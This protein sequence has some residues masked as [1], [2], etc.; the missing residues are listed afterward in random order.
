[1]SVSD[2][3]RLLARQVFGS[4]E[5]TPARH[6]APPIVEPVHAPL[7]VDPNNAGDEPKGYPVGIVGESHY[8]PAVRQLREGQAICL[9]PEPT[10]RYDPKAIKVCTEAG[11]TIGYIAKDSF[12]QRLIHKERKS[13][14]AVVQSINRTESAKSMLGV[15]IYVTID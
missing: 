8:Q 9:V 4:R 13:C 10:N 15:V 3:L 6:Q 1:M 2:K 5:T 12:V 7:H 14:S 11:Q